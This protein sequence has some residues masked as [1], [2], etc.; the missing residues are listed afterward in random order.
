MEKE[1]ICDCCGKVCKGDGVGTGYGISL[2][3]KNICYSCCAKADY[4]LLDS[5]K[6]GDKASFYLNVDSNEIINWPGTMRIHAYVRKGLH[7]IAGVRYD[8]YFSYNGKRFW[9]VRYGQDNEICH[10]KRIK[11]HK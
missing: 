2:D 9:G 10:I 5:M 6:V 7:N 4:T 1:V 3:N 8:A 11:W